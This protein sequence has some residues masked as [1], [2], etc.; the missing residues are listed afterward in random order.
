MAKKDTIIGAI[1][2]WFET[3][4][5][6]QEIKPD[7]EINADN[8]PENAFEYCIETVP[9]D[10]VITS[11]VDGS[12]IKQYLFLFAGREVFGDNTDNLSNSA[13][14]EEVADW[15]EE[16]TKAKILPALPKGME[17]Q[18][19]DVLTNGYV[20]DNDETKARYQIQCRLVYYKSAKY[21]TEVEI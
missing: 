11:Y 15:I 13:I 10:P 9:C 20:L 3:C 16:Q 17:A 21:K 14:Y 6:L 12:A 19:L 8:L 2:K 1:I 7:T 18:K 4:P 5:T